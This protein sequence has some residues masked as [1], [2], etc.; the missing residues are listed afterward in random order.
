MREY[1]HRRRQMRNTCIQIN[2]LLRYEQ[3]PRAW[4]TPHKRVRL[5]RALVY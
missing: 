5:R 4:T 1:R 3:L 2:L